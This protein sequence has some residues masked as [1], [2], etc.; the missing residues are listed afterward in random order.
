M[1]TIQTLL[2]RMHATA[3]PFMIYRRRPKQPRTREAWMQDRI[4][5]AV[6]IDTTSPR[7][8]YSTLCIAGPL[9]YFA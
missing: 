2:A 3:E 8:H 9:M 6:Y 7:L 5:T 4:H 1:Q